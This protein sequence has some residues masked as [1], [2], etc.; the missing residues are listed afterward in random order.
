MTY[1]ISIVYRTVNLRP[2]TP[3]ILEPKYLRNYGTTR[4]KGW[5]VQNLRSKPPS[6]TSVQNLR[7]KPELKRNIIDCSTFAVIFSAS[8]SHV[9]SIDQFDLESDGNLCENFILFLP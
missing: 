3:S 5:F 9:N 6:K 7:S 4:L 1:M 2:A 8:V